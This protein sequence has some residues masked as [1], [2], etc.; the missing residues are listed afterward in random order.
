MKEVAKSFTD[1]LASFFK[2]IDHREYHDDIPDWYVTETVT[3]RL[4]LKEKHKITTEPVKS[5]TQ[6]RCYT[7]RIKCTLV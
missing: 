2:K 4:V 5:V 1:K 6:F 7:E 3:I